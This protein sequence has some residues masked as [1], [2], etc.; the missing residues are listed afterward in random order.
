D[1]R[2]H[3]QYGEAHAFFAVSLPYSRFEIGLPALVPNPAVELVLCDD[4]DGVA[5]RAAARAASLGYANVRVLAGG[6]PGW[7]RA[8]F[9]LYAGVNVPSKAF[10]ELVEQ[11]RGTPARQR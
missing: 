8:G 7:A 2:E 4:D 11:A 1:V 6:A 5:L 10:G 3:G 9:T